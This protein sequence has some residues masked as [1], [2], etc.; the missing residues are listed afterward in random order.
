MNKK[1][2]LLLLYLMILFYMPF[3]RFIAQSVFVLN[4]WR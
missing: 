3:L 4:N 1:K 2:S